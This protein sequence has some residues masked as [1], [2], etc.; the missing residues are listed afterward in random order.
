MSHIGSW[1]RRIR[2]GS[3]V[4]PTTLYHLIESEVADRLV[5]RCGRE[6]TYRR[7][8]PWEF[9]EAPADVVACNGCRRKGAPE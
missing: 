6:L 7:E 8:R 2:L 1:A 5:M 3:E 9:S 4:V